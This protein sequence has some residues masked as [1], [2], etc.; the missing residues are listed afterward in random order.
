MKE[1][2][3]TQGSPLLPA[4]AL[5][6]ARPKPL[7][8]VVHVLALPGTPGHDRPLAAIIRTARQEAAIYR[9]EGIDGII[10]ENMHDVPYLK[11]SVGPEIVASMTAVAAAVRAAVPE[12]PLGIQILAGANRE[13]LAVAHAAGLDYVRAEGYVFAH[14]ADEGLVESCAGELLRYRRAMGAERVQ[15]WAD[16]K[17]KHSA[18]A[19]TADV[20]LAETV[21]AVEFFQGDAVIITGRV[22][23]EAPALEDLL[24][25]QAA[26]G[27]PVL[28]GSGLTPE[29]LDRYWEAADG[30]IVGSSLKEGGR[31]AN[32]VDPKRVRKLVA[33]KR[34]LG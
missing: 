23:G 13:A 22:T 9:D 17:K 11:G 6:F 19:I 10:V 12:L 15:V 4:R 1:E 33:R 26:A 21:Q 7:I 18:H 14:V 25:A 27:L 30:F 29:D 3:A 16:V 24:E 2:S 8:G 20:S 34:A 5:P 28:L 32:P 31:W